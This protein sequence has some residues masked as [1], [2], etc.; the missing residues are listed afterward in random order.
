M[1]TLH[2]NSHK[3]RRRSFQFKTLREPRI[4]GSML[5]FRSPKTRHMAMVENRSYQDPAALET[6]N[7]TVR[8][9]RGNTRVAHAWGG[10]DGS[11]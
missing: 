5:R 6:L 7:A 9:Q 10:G 1:R 8:G 11:E 4:S 2:S 3:S